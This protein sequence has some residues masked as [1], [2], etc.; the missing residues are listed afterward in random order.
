MIVS[1]LALAL[2]AGPLV[3]SPGGRYPTVASAV[4]AA[5]AGATIT[6][7]AGH[8]R[9]PTIVVDRPLTL[10]GDS[11]AVLDGEARHEI[12]VV[13]A[14]NVVVRNLTFVN[15]GFS[16]SEDRAAL[17]LDR[18]VGCRVSANRFERTFFA[19][20]LAAA[21]R[22]V[23]DSNVVAGSGSRDEVGT[24]SGIHL[25]SCRDV[26]VRANRI[27][28]HRDGIYLEFSHHA[29][30]EGNL[31]AG[32]NRYG[33]HF[34]YSDSSTY[35]DNV[36]RGNGSGVAVMYTRSVTMIG[37]TFT[38]DRGATA[39]GLLLKEISDARLVDNLFRDNT[40]AL[41]ADGANR[42]VAASNRFVRNGWAIRL[43]GSTDAGRF[44]GNVFRGNS[45]DVA[46][47]DRETSSVFARNFWDAYRGWDLDHDGVG[48]VPH[49]PV[50]LFAV[51]A[52][53]ATPV[54]LLQRSLFVR[55]LDAAEHALPVLTPTAVV[56]AQPLM[57]D[58]LGGR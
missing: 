48:D 46:V 52:E 41:L 9:E 44:E 17:R 25:W 4:A 58:P 20:Y 13:R 56:D 33:L 10:I 11:G 35:R 28:G 22:C 49:H 12:L 6:I 1:L 5:P 43:L 37:N 51:L 32:N 24:G 8:Y 34:M 14:P 21:E 29:D 50:R 57:R 7:S 27:T 3:V 23:V 47:N 55:L 53:R 26:T 2:Q 36:F 19:I 30:V 42:L 18:A 15:T 38:A 45:F 54:M 40:T 31:S 39:Y 16:Y